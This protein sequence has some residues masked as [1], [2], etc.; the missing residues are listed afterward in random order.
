MVG[1]IGGILEEVQRQVES[2]AAGAFRGTLH[3]HVYGKDGVM[4]PAEPVKRTA[5]HELGILIEAISPTQEEADSLVSVTRSTLLHYGY[6]GR[7]S[8]AGNLAFPF[9]PSDIRMGDVYD[10][11]VYH[12]MEIDDPAGFPLQIVPVGGGRR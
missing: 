7:I 5:S 3:F 1:N 2:M 11:S 10:F 9:S 12:L 6:P 4:G 8:T